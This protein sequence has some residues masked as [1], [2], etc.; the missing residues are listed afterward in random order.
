M[1]HASVLRSLF[2][3]LVRSGDLMVVGIQFPPIEVLLQL[4]GI[5]LSNGAVIALNAIGVTLVYG[6]IRTLN[7]AHGDLF[8]LTTVVVT[9]IVTSLG[10]RRGLPTATLAG[11]LALA[12]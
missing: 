2:F 3:V 12:L 1:H 4:L 10:L 9:T 11:G 6:A 7:F 8:A 5:G